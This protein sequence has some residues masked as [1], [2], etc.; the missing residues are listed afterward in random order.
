MS[1]SEAPIAAIAL[2][3]CAW[4]S[5]ALAQDTV[6]VRVEQLLQT[7]KQ[8]YS[9]PTRPRPGRCAAGRPGE[10]VV[11]APDSGEDQRVPSTADSDPGSREAQR[12]LN[13]GIPHADVG[14]HQSGTVVATGCFIPPCPKPPVYIVDFS[15]LPPPPPGSDAERIANGEA[16]AP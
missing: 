4:P 1:R 8:A 14:T 5:A 10:I 16:R 11:C 12:A 6:E 3:V 7:A 2:A 13:N 15:K 9:L